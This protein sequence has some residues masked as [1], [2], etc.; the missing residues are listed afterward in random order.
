MFRLSLLCG[1]MPLL[2]ACVSTTSFTDA[3]SEEPAV[4]QTQ[5]N[6]IPRSVLFGNP[7]R[8]SV[9]ISPDGSTLS[10]L[11]PDDGVMNIWVAPVD[12]LRSARVIT[13]DR[14][15]GI[16]RY[17]WAET[18]DHLVYLQDR[19]GDENFR[20]YSVELE[21][22]TELNLTPFENVRAQIYTSSQMRPEWL[23][24]GLNNRDP[25][26]HDAYLVNVRT[27]ELAL[28]HEN[29][30]ELRE[31]IFDKDLA[32][33]LGARSM[34][35]GSMV[36]FKISQGQTEKLYTLAYDDVVSSSVIGFAE[37]GLSY[38]AVESLDLD[39]AALFEVHAE[40]GLRAMIAQSDKAD[41]RSV[42][43][44]PSNQ[45]IEAY[46]VNYLKSNWNALS[47]SIAADLTLIEDKLEGEF[48]VLSRSRDDRTWVVGNQSARAGLSFALYD[49]D[50][51]QLT[52]L[53]LAQP[54]LAAYELQEMH[55]VEI[56]SR[57]GLALISYLTLPT[58]SDANNDGRPDDPVPL[59]L[60]VHG[61][62]WARNSYGYNST[63][64]WLANRGYAV[65]SVNFRS[66]TGFGK[67]FITAGDGEWGAK[68]QE[69]LLDAVQ[70]AVDQGIAKHDQVA[71]TGGSYGG[72]AA[73]AGLTFT[74][75]DF[76]CGVSIVG[77]SN[78]ETLMQTI[79]PYWESIRSVFHRAIGDPETEEGLALL[80]ER[81]PLHRA[82]HITKPL[83]I[84]QGAND[85]RVKQ[86]E[87][88]QI[89][90]ALKRSEIPFTYVL[91]PDEG[92]GFARPQNRMAFY[93]VMESFLGACLG[94]DTQDFENAFE[95]SSITVV[96]GA[97][98]T[99]GLEQAIMD[100]TA[101]II[102]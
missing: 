5:G 100:H 79:P 88:D 85:P 12:D 1:L 78:L 57:D 95:G 52:P 43:I 22:G 49:N 89:A 20:L 98:H 87:S 72:Y 65:L 36:R 76:A 68:M 54:E 4:V 10:W 23:A 33:R 17:V 82:D 26:W 11:A 29:S 25:A 40:T 73:L 28:V 34:P 8:A 6:L 13:S 42:M 80:Q 58:G 83:L 37:D 62:P 24:I 84:G 93:A 61:G 102:R 59:V 60:D 64:Q 38:F 99:P 32:L 66:S 91:F 74:P 21:T 69:D 9:R 35:D 92:H 47:S 39:R 75:D 77:P 30:Q 96:N 70:W 71:I 2:A 18:N 101:S 14:G 19:A 51:N 50:Q 81:S 67:A 48:R 53:F 45:E 55:P 7:T 3:S 31:L 41:L 86:S 46:S 90:E 63:H 27:G 15:R 56:P 94:G 44:N 97:Q 16:L